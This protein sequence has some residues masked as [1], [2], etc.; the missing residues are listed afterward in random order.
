MHIPSGSGRTQT[1]RSWAALALRVRIE[2]GCMRSR[3]ARTALRNSPGVRR[4]PVRVSSR[5]RAAMPNSSAHS[6]GRAEVSSVTTRA[7]A[8]VRV[9]LSRPSR[10]AICGPHRASAAPTSR[11][12]ANSEI[13]SATAT[14]DTASA[15][16]RPRR[17]APGRRPAPR[18]ARPRAGPPPRTRAGPAPRRGPRARPGTSGPARCPQDPPGVPA[19]QRR[20]VR[21]PQRPLEQ[22]A[23]P[24]RV[25][26]RA[27]RLG[28]G[29]PATCRTRSPAMMPPTP[30]ENSYLR[31]ADSDHEF[32]ILFDQWWIR[33][34]ERRGVAPPPSRHGR[35]AANAGLP[36]YV[37]G[38]DAPGRGASP[39]R[40]GTSSAPRGR[41]NA[42]RRTPEAPRGSSGRDRR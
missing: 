21:V 2:S 35:R 42:R 26:H 15:R 37:S 28:R 23:R 33:N 39:S 3:R 27:R 32:E 5:P 10:T 36:R 38:A 29:G 22:R 12:A 9:P 7:W 19:G 18:T 13:P 30:I 24:R 16:E 4:R 20:R 31:V 8:S 1:P 41:R 34:L 17:S 14:S 25:D 40:A 11:A 6:D